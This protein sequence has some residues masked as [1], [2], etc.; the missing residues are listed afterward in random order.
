VRPDFQAC[1]KRLVA[2]VLLAG[3]SLVQ[4]GQDLRVLVSIKPIH[5]IVAGLMQDIGEPE[6]L[7]DETSSI[8]DP[9]LTAEQQHKLQQARLVIWVGPELEQ[10]LPAALNLLTEETQVIELLSSPT[11]KILPSR[12]EPASRDAF[13]WLDDRN[14]IILLDDLTELL[15]SH[16]PRRAHVYARNR[17]KMLQP[18]QHIDKQYEY[19]YRGLKAGVSVQ[20]YDTLQY[21]EQAYALKPLGAITSLQQTG[22][23]A[24]SLLKMRASMIEHNGSCVLLDKSRSGAHLD[25]LTAGR[26]SNIGELDVLGSQFAAGPQLYLQLMQY[27]TDVI[28]QCLN[29]DAPA[30]VSAGHVADDSDIPHSDGIGGRFILTDHFGRAV[31][32]QDMRGHYSL[33]FFGYTFCPDVCPTSLMVLSQA[34]RLMGEQAND[35]QAYF[36]TVDPERDSV[37]V[38]HDYVGYFD[39]RLLGLTGTKPMI[40]RVADQFRVKFQRVEAPSGDPERYGVDH[41]ASLYLMAPDGSFV[42][43]FA[44]GITPEALVSELQ[45]IMRQ[46]R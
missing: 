2:V 24:A 7:F 46:P 11:M 25:L 32:E 18:L 27:N 43:K 19:S 41:S 8:F 40:Q 26:A 28:K 17:L 31:T 13:F 34:F 16:D 6:L 45:A 33:V 1:L 42:T 15:I 30:P 20:Y 44:H 21:F 14:I 4:A 22:D 5:S 38:L 29:A 37:K 3:A 9:Q 35:M 12:R 39:S 36:I 23:D 10:A